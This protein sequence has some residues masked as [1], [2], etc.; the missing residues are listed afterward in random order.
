ME[1]G[2]KIWNRICQKEKYNIAQNQSFVQTGIGCK[3]KVPV[4]STFLSKTAILWYKLILTLYSTNTITLLLYKNFL[5]SIL[6]LQ[7]F[8]LYYL[9]F[10]LIFFIIVTKYFIK[11]YITSDY[12]SKIRKSL[13]SSILPYFSGNKLYA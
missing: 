11:N 2:Y 9:F 12:F 5:K 10:G 3:K 1:E 4:S 6:E 13:H 8:L 7:N